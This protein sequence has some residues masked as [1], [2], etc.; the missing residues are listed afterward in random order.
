MN[1]WI[2]L[3]NENEPLEEVKSFQN[4]ECLWEVFSRIELNQSM[5]Y[6]ASLE[7]TSKLLLSFFTTFWM[8]K[9]SRSWIWSIIKPQASIL[10]RIDGSSSRLPSLLKN[11]VT[12][13]WCRVQRR[14]WLGTSWLFWGTRAQLI[15]TNGL[16]SFLWVL[17]CT[18]LPIWVHY[19]YL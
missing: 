7:N 13:S 3:T 2:Y 14:K 8:S 11:Q 18:G 1:T 12:S 10:L 16:L 6:S 4:D 5:L 15:M 17:I 19:I 9:K